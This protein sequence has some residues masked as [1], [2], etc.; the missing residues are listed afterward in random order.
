MP[1]ILTFLI[2][3]SKFSMLSLDDDVNGRGDPKFPTLFKDF[4]TAA[5]TPS[6]DISVLKY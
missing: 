6:L 5:K 4:V 1:Q 2:L 3:S